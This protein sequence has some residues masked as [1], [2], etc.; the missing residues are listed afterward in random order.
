M[1]GGL[2]EPTK[3]KITVQHLWLVRDQMRELLQAGTLDQQTITERLMR[4]PIYEQFDLSEEEMF[5]FVGLTVMIY[6]REFIF[7]RPGR[8]ICLAKRVRR[9]GM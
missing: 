2:M 9:S 8:L 5:R 6:D 3:P 4:L 1:A 7:E